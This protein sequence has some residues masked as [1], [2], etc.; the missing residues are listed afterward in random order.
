MQYHPHSSSCSNCYPSCTPIYV[1]S[2]MICSS[3][4]RKSNSTIHHHHHFHYLPPSLSSYCCQFQYC[5]SSC[6]HP[7]KK[8]DQCHCCDNTSPTNHTNTPITNK[9]NPNVDHNINDSNIN[10]RQH[11]YYPKQYKLLH[12][13][14]QELIQSERDYVADLSIMVEICLAELHQQKWISAEHVAIM[15]CNKPDILAFHRKLLHTLETLIY[16]QHQKQRLDQ[17]N[18]PI[19]TMETKCQTIAQVFLQY[20]SQFMD[21]YTTY[22]DSHSNRWKLCTEYR[23]RSEWSDFILHCQALIQVR[24]E[25]SSSSSSSSSSTPIKHIRFE[26][27]LIKPIQRICRYQ[28]LLKE[29]IRHANQYAAS[30]GFGYPTLLIQAFDSMYDIATEIDRQ[31]EK[32]EDVERTNR[33]IERLESDWRLSRHR[34]AQLGCLVISG[35]LDIKYYSENNHMHHHHESSPSFPSSATHVVNPVNA[36][37]SSYLGCFV[38][39]SYII[40]VQVKKHTLY[41]AKHWFP[42]SIVN[43]LDSD[44]DTDFILQCQQHVFICSTTCNKE[45]QTWMEKIRSAQRTSVNTLQS[46]FG[47]VSSFNDP[48]QTLERDQ[49]LF[50]HSPTIYF[51]PDHS[52][53]HPHRCPLS[54]SSSSPNLWLAKQGKQKDKRSSSPRPSSNIWSLPSSPLSTINKRHSSLDLFNLTTRVSLHFKTHHRNAHREAVDQ[55]LRDVCTRDYLSS[56]R[57]LDRKSSVDPQQTSPRVSSSVASSPTYALI[58]SRTPSPR[59]SPITTNHDTLIAQQSSNEASM[60]KKKDQDPSSTNMQSKH[61]TIRWVHSFWHR[62]KKSKKNK[63]R[64]PQPIQEEEDEKK[65][66]HNEKKEKNVA[67]E[68]EVIKQEQDKLQDNSSSPSTLYSD[69]LLYRRSFQLD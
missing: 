48:S 54:S 52:Y 55:R 45:R 67:I 41:D 69:F 64:P 68:E 37:K 19:I 13:A 57:T 47:L 61:M 16:D 60:R 58:H 10:I 51:D 56:R 25:A 20:E 15:S 14:I 18:H 11:H 6:T 27:F 30:S 39:S 53:Y 7:K 1:P 46:S 34:V 63:K 33:F 12:H 21:L 29:I 9:N 23:G 32:R 28:L 3:C 5:Y 36:M 62:L 17:T 2:P 38:F 24:Y 35:A 26:D 4:H 22:C 31:N 43:L 49:I 59:P 44:N 66:K 42:L 65:E 40:M 8:K 50:P